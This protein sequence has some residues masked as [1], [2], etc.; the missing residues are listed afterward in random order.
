MDVIFLIAGDRAVSVEFGK[1]ICIETNIMYICWD[2]PRV[3]LIWQDLR[4][5]TTLREGNLPV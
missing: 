3:I 1:V 2:S 5:P 4:N